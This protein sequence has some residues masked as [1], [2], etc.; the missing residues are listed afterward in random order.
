MP[1]K[2]D[3]LKLARR[4]ARALLPWI[5]VG[6]SSYHHLSHFE[7]DGVVIVVHSPADGNARLSVFAAL[8]VVS[9]VPGEC[10]SLT[11][12]VLVSQHDEAFFKKDCPNWR[13]MQH[14]RLK[15]LIG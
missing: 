12:T 1:D 7:I 3:Y 10:F 15:L 6:K 4:W 9:M 5:G 13:K 8:P 2:S 11:D 14:A